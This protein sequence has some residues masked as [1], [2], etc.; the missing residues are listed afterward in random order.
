MWPRDGDTRGARLRSRP[1]DTAGSHRELVSSALGAT[2]GIALAFGAVR[3]FR[4]ASPIELTVGADVGIHPAV[5]GFSIA[6]AFATTLIFGLLP[7]LRASGRGLRAG[8]H[9]LARTVIAAEMALSFLLLIGAGLLLASAFR[10]GS[11]PLGFHPERVL[12]SGISL[13]LDRYSTDEQRRR[14]YQQL[15]DR[16]D[17]LPGTAGVALASKIPPDAGGNQVLEIEG[18][19]AGERQRNSRCRRGLCD[20]HLLRRFEHCAP[21]RARVAH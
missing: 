4:L 8:R 11:E 14:A 18:Q 12:A 3:Y 15:L 19:A 5:L 13:P 16:V 21:A 10:M 1:A 6:L 20:S 2:L 9:V 7:A 17:R